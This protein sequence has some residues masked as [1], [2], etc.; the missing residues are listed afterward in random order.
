M[1]TKR[2][3]K[4]NLIIS[5]KNLTPELQELLKQTYPEGYRNYI[6]HFEKPNGDTIYVVPIETEDTCYMVKVDVKIDSAMA[7]EAELDNALFGNTDSDDSMEFE[8]LDIVDKDESGDTDHRVT[9]LQFGDYEENLAAAAEANKVQ[10]NE[11]LSKEFM[12]AFGDDF[13]DEFGSDDDDDD[14]YADS[15]DDLDREPSDEELEAE[16]EPS[17]EDIMGMEDEMGNLLFPEDAIAQEKPKRGR[18]PKATTATPAEPK[19][20]G[21]KKKDE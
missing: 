2:N 12:E 20:R 19:K 3:A 7:A 6:Q 5:Q 8:P 10:K 16:F 9:H 13:K 21:R 4:K 14:E 17:D 15:D 11:A 18:K 1:K